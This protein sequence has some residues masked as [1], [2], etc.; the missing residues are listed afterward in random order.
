MTDFRKKFQ[1]IVD[2]CMSSIVASCDL[3]VITWGIRA[4]S[5]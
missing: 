3:E 4:Q 2:P 1:T 5:S